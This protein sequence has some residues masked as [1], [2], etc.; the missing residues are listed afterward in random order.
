MTDFISEVSNCIS[1]LKS[2]IVAPVCSHNIDDVTCLFDDVT[3]L[4]LVI[5]YN[6]E[7][8]KIKFCNIMKLSAH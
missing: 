1:I 4:F 8:N 2:R 6:L 5:D 3:C 7:D